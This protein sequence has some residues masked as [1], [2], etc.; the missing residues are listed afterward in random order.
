MSD[1]MC[2]K[3]KYRDASACISP[4]VVCKY[5]YP[6]DS[7]SFAFRDSHFVPEGSG[8]TPEDN[9]NKGGGRPAYYA[10]KAEC[11]DVML[12]TMGPDDVKGF[13]LCN[14]F[15]Y[16]WRCKQKHDAADKDAQKAVW[17]MQKYLELRGKS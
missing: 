9:K 1:N 3:C 10:G 6:K 15:K 12:D 13:C 16:I 14:A 4:C 2:E 17:Y 11:I 5:A 7:A 8:F